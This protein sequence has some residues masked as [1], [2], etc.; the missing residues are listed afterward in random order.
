MAGKRVTVRLDNESECMLQELARAQGITISDA[1]RVAIANDWKR[2]HEPDVLGQ[3]MAKLDGLVLLRDATQTQRE[4]VQPVQD[5][6]SKANLNN[7]MQW[8]DAC[9]RVDA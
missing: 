6:H 1:A 4:H 5:K 3:I 7:V 8:M 2:R 9:D